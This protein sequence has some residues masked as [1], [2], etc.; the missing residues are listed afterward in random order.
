LVYVA[1]DTSNHF[2]WLSGSEGSFRAAKLVRLGPGFHAQSGSNFRAWIDNGCTPFELTASVDGY[3]P[4]WNKRS[5][6]A[7][8][9]EYLSWQLTATPNPAAD[10]VRISFQLPS[11]QSINL[12]LLDSNGSVVSSIMP[13]TH[14]AAGNHNKNVSLSSLPVGTYRVILQSE[15]GLRASTTL[16]VVR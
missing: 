15:G 16:L 3:E 14:Y 10:R 5:I 11:D 7:K 13:R 6:H 8:D 4:K 12:Y 1:T 2:E 9:Q